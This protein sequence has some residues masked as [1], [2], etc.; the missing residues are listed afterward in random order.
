MADFACVT[1]NVKGLRQKAK[2][3]KIFEFLKTKVPCGII[4]L[5]E[6]HCVDTDLEEWTNELDCDVFLN[7]GSSNSCGTLIA[8]TKNLN[9]TIS[10]NFKDDLGRLQIISC[11]FHEKKFL[12]INIYNENTQKG[13]NTLLEKLISILENF[14]DLQDHQIIIGG[15]WNFILDKNLDALGGSPQLKL[16]SISKLLKINEKY[17]LIDIYRVRYPNQKRFTFRQNSPRRLRRLDFFIISNS[18]QESVK[19]I[20]V[21]NSVSSDHSPVLI[22]ICM[23]SEPSRG[24]NYWKFNASLLQEEDFVEKM[25]NK[26]DELKTTFA[27][28]P[29]KK[30]G[31]F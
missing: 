11:T 10:Y 17:D 13:Q 20:D 7:S 24:S 27:D 29:L 26:I 23:G 19:K 25:S 28:S 22:K 2:R 15:D 31:N 5:Q 12:F 16:P 9:P 18:L 1:Y 30:N 14:T 6:A 21:L 8:F 3:V 4:M